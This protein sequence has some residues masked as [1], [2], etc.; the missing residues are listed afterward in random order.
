MAYSAFITDFLQQAQLPR[1]SAHDPPP[2]KQMI[3]QVAGA[4]EREIAPANGS[5]ASC[6]RSLLLLAAGGIEEAHRIVQEMSTPS[7]A[8]IHGVIHRIDDDF[9]NAKYWFRRAG[10]FPA[11]EEMYRRGAANSLTIARHPSWDPVL[12]TD[13]L[14]TSRTTGVTEELQAVLTVEFEALL[15]FLWNAS[16]PGN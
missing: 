3:Q 11:G 8:Y 15:E 2:D 5:Q 14:E 13:M 12:V 1:L 16:E 9:D 10:I 4:E 6:I 7:A